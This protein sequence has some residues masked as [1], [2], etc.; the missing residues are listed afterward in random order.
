VTIL[1]GP[2]FSPRSGHTLRW[3]PPRL[4]RLDLD[5]DIAAGRGLE[6]AVVQSTQIGAVNSWLR[7][8]P[9]GVVAVAI[10]SIRD[11]LTG[12][13]EAR[14]YACPARR[15]CPQRASLSK[16]RPNLTCL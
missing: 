14:A 5:L 8:E 16:G 13:M 11:A 9:A 2:L 10:A 7:G 4:D 1:A 6:E 12:H 3:A 15:G